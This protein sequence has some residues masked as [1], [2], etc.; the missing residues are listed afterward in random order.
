MLL[1]GTVLVVVIVSGILKVWPF[2]TV[3]TAKHATSTLAVSFT[4]ILACKFAVVMIVT[5]FERIMTFHKKYNAEK[6]Y[7]FL[8]SL[9]TKYRSSFLLFAK[10]ILSLGSLPILYGIWLSQV[11]YYEYGDFLHSL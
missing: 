6:N 2:I 5:I 10:V 4:T 9:V 3:S 11:D 1:I 8:I 7:N